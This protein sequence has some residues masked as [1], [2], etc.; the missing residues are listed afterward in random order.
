M[1]F[2]NLTM[3]HLTF[4]STISLPWDASE[5]PYAMA[6]LDMGSARKAWPENPAAWGPACWFL[7][8]RQDNRYYMWCKRNQKKSWCWKLLPIVSC[9][10]KSFIMSLVST[11][12]GTALTYRHPE[13]QAQL[14]WC[15]QTAGCHLNH[16]QSCS[17]DAYWALLENRQEIKS[18][19]HSKRSEGVLIQDHYNIGKNN[20]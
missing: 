15:P 12:M 18:D 20:K 16:L 1:E 17:S 9:R 5:L 7:S 6:R 3:S 13:I 2:K 19:N 4:L 10:L 8:A 11:W 14:H